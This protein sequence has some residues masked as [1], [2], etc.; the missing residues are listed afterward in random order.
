MKLC[1]KT[2]VRA[3]LFLCLAASSV[4]AQGTREDY[5]RAQ[6]F[7]PGNLRHRVYVADVIPHWIAEKNR[8]WYRKAGTKATEFILVD[9]EQN[10]S[11]AAFDHVRL[12]ASLTKAAK[13]D[14]QPTGLPFDTF[15]YAKDGKSIS[16]QMDG[17]P[18][19]CQLENYEC[20]KAPEPIAGQYEE[21]SP[22]KE[23]VAYVQEHD[24]YLRYVSTGEIVR[25]TRDGET[26]WDYATPIPSL[27]PMIS[28]GTPGCEA[29]ACGV[30]VA[31]FLKA[32][33]LPDGHAK[34]GALHEFAV[35]STRAASPQG[36]HRCLPLA[37]RSA[38]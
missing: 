30:L 12:A 23:W 32:R 27:R 26:S 31:G 36:I 18:W 29:A 24:L 35:R 10:T 15:E 7:L 4:K 13:R 11:G 3:A 14:V 34:C 5:E 37:R 19:T 28:Q 2:W 21:A 25:L 33:Q 20:K 1:V 16:F 17:M 38:A 8:F 9:A 22:N 6:Q